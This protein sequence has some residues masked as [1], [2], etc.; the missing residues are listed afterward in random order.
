MSPADV[1]AE[2][3]ETNLPNLGVQV[4]VN[5]SPDTPASCILV[6]DKASANLERRS[7]RSGVIDEHPSVYIM[8]RGQDSSAYAIAQQI[9][10]MAASV[11][12]Q[13]V[14]SG[15]KLRVITKSNTIGFSGQE[16]QTRR[17]VYAQTYR[18]TLE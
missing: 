6:Y 15:Q 18:M 11:Y 2:I 13:P 17:Y 12:D 16:P 1:V 8:V 4:F 3:I 14:S 5:H 9:E 7:L 10:S